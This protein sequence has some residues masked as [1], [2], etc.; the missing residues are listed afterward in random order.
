MEPA[1]TPTT[2]AGT[3]ETPT[4]GRGKKGFLLG[5]LS[6]FLVDIDGFSLGHVEAP[7]NL[8]EKQLVEK[9]S[10]LLWSTGCSPGRGGNG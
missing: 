1:G 2:P 10:N 5:Y 9:L 7:L 3:W 8:K 6:L 4:P